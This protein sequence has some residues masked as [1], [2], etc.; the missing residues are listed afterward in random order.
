MKSNPLPTRLGI[1]MIDT[2][3]LRGLR[4]CDAVT[5]R[6]CAEIDRLEG[7]AATAMND[8]DALSEKLR[9]LHDEWLEQYPDMEDLMAGIPT[10]LTSVK[11]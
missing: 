10:L 5:L 11:R 9:Q 1:R 2:E 3:Y 7:L 6:L 4:D 8:R